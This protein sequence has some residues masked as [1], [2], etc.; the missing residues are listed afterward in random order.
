MYYTKLKGLWDHFACVKPRRRCARCACCRYGYNES[1]ARD[2]EEDKVHQFLMGLNEEYK[3][4]TDQIIMM[5]PLPNIVRVCSIVEKVE[6]QRVVKSDY[7]SLG[8]ISAMVG[9]RTATE[10]IFE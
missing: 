8:Q 1:V 3:A 2:E 6:K 5:D 4:I 10:E 9:Q 7:Q